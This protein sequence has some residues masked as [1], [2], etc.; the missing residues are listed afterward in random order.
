MSL[1][2]TTTSVRSG[3]RSVKTVAGVAPGA[4]G[5]IGSVGMRRFDG[6]KC[7]MTTATV[8]RV[9]GICLGGALLARQALGDR[10]E[11]VGRVDADR[12]MADQWKSN[13]WWMRLIRQTAEAFASRLRELLPTLQAP[14][15]RETAY[16]PTAEAGYIA[17]T[18]GPNVTAIEKRHLA[19]RLL[20]LE[21]PTQPS[22]TAGA[23]R[24]SPNL[25]DSSPTRKPCIQAASGRVQTR[26]NPR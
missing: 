4:D 15:M 26:H 21:G 24:T 19:H 5:Q 1:S 13:C 12:A 9:D 7:S 17:A 25:S 18:S 3:G 20:A 6:R 22:S 2:M 11:P 23:S 10:C 14:A 8:L 16:S